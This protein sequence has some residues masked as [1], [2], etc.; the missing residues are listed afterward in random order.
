MLVVLL[1]R[2]FSR[3][4]RRQTSAKMGFGA[5]PALGCAKGAENSDDA[6][7]W[8]AWP[9]MDTAYT[10]AKSMNA[11]PFFEHFWDE[12]KAW[13]PYFIQYCSYY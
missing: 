8:N 9:K 4:F 10:Y 3:R 13:T 5:K 11:S 6:I 7:S 1:Y 2:K 12:N